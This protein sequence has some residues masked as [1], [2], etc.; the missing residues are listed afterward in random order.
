LNRKINLIIG[1]NTMERLGYAD[2]LKLGDFFHME[3]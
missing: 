3:K 2:H 1:R